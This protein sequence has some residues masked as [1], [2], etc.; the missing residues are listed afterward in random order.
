MYQIKLHST[1]N[2]HIVADYSIGGNLI[3]LNRTSLIEGQWE[4]VRIGISVDELIGLGEIMKLRQ[5]QDKKGIKPPDHEL[6]DQQNGYGLW[7]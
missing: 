4:T 6:P 3:I 1:P 7:E 5:A 2:H